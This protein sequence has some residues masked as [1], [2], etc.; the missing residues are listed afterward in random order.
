MDNQIGTGALDSL[1]GRLLNIPQQQGGIIPA[2]SPELSAALVLELDR[3]E[4][5]F[6]K[7]ER[8]CAGII[9]VVGAAAVR[10]RWR[11]RNPV[12]SGALIV[13]ESLGICFP[14]TTV[15]TFNMA[16]GVATTDRT[17]I[18][19]SVQRDSRSGTQRGV[20]VLSGDNDGLVN[21]TGTLFEVDVTATVGN[22]TPV[23]L[24]IILAPGS[25]IDGECGQL[26]QEI[27]A[28]IRWREREIRQYEIRT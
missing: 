8:C 16:I 12:N 25:H 9:D 17:N 4:W 13:I 2:V 5:C 28:N 26:N 27:L 18:V 19:A 6:L 23:N 11:F 3:P 1:V 10:S 7:G 24:P 21:L 15:S 20:A 14:V 22:I